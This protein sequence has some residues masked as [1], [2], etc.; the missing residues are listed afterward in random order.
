M[1]GLR[2]AAGVPDEGLARRFVESQAG[3]RF[4]EA[5]VIAR[6]GGRIVV[7]EP[8]LTDAVV[9]EALSVSAVDC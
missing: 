7:R 2:L 4:L 3:R 9:R 8:M 1:L 6:R 5:D